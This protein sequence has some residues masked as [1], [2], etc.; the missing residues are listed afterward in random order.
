MGRKY[1]LFVNDD[2]ELDDL[3]CILVIDFYCENKIKI[4]LYDDYFE[5]EYLLCYFVVKRY[6]IMVYIIGYIEVDEVVF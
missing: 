4:N 6:V 3:K 1:E 5:K 2:K